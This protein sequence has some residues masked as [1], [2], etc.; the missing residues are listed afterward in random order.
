MTI[1][2]DNGV[3]V[4]YMGGPRSGTQ[5]HFDRDPRKVCCGP[6]A[7]AKGMFGLYETETV[8]NGTV[9]MRWKALAVPKITSPH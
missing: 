3:I 9:V 6:E 1:N 2:G 7:K 4:R 5:Q 8:A